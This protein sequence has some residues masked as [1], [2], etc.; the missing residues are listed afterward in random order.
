MNWLKKL[1]ELRL[2]HSGIVTITDI[3]NDDKASDN[4]DDALLDD[5]KSN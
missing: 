5:S 3:E 4:K 1:N 2:E